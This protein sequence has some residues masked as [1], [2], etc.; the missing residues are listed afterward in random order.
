MI[1]R[2]DIVRECELASVSDAQPQAASRPKS[3]ARRLL[4]A[5]LLV[6]ADSG[7]PED[8]SQQL[9]DILSEWC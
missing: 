7:R 1:L 8:S 2:P 4:R 6:N 9:A 3:A 5:H